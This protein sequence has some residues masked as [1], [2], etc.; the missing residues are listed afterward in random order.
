MQNFLT[1]IL[2]GYWLSILPIVLW[3]HRIYE[4]RCNRS[5]A[6]QCTTLKYRHKNSMHTMKRLCSPIEQ[7]CH[8]F[9]STLLNKTDVLIMKI[10]INGKEWPLKMCVR[11][12]CMHY[13]LNEQFW[14][15]IIRGISKS[16]RQELSFLVECI[17]EWTV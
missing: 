1:H 14:L 11:K 16:V 17:W 4:I 5:M 10:T 3:N 12:L 15:N 8:F 9:P 7:K 6:L 13:I 2:S